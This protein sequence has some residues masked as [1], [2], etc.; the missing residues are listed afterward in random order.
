[1]QAD[2]WQTAGGAH[3]GADGAGK[4]GWGCGAY[5]GNH[6]PLF[7]SFGERDLPAPPCVS[8][9]G[10]G[11][12]EEEELSSYLGNE[13]DVTLALERWCDALLLSD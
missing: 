6:L 3:G 13:S 5:Y 2:G 12:E 9:A 11:V 1:M 8:S 10:L 4:A 7:V